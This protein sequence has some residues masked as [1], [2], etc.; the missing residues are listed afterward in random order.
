MSGYISLTPQREN[1]LVERVAKFIA[2]SDIRDFL[3]MLI[4]TYGLTNFF[5]SFGFILAYPYAV[6]LLGDVG[7]D[8]TEFVGLN[9]VG[10]SQR[11]L[12]RVEELELEYKNQA[13]NMTG[14][15]ARS[16]SETDGRSI[17]ARLVSFLRS[18][19]NV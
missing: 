6:G 13:E 16:Q 18:R 9:P 15:N 5:G 19:L 1:E 7:Q 14:E 10:N 11:I 8:F 4:S 3:K 17:S 12:K 2:K